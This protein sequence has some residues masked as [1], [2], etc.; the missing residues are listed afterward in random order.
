MSAMVPVWLK[1]LAPGKEVRLDSE[2]LVPD[3]SVVEDTLT[4]LA[5]EVDE[6]VSGE[7]TAFESESEEW[8]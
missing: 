3:E 1:R 7:R 2:E 5:D 6:G 4:H 8:E